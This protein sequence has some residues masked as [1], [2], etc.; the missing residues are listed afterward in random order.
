MSEKIGVEI[1]RKSN[2]KK[3]RNEIIIEALQGILMF[4]MVNYWYYGLLKWEK[5]LLIYC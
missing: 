2:L 1:F 4:Q 5:S 3:V